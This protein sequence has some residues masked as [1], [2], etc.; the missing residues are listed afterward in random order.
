MLTSIPDVRN[1][2]TLDCSNC[3]WIEPNEEQI[4]KLVRLQQW[5]DRYLRRK[6]LE[7]LIK[8][9]NMY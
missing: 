4:N 5:F 2:E 1:L 8:L 7:K 3:P 9:V 6:R